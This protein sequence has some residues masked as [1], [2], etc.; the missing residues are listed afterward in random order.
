MG[1]CGR[2]KGVIEA[3]RDVNDMVV[4]LDDCSS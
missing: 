2:E 4:F 3:N 1:I